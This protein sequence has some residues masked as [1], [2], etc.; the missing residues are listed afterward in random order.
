M[1]HPF[2]HFFAPLDECAFLLKNFVLILEGWAAYNTNN[3]ND[4]TREST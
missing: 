3:H 2:S 1:L 4:Q